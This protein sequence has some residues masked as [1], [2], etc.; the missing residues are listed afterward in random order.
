LRYAMKFK[1]YENWQHFIVFI[2]SPDTG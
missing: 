1:L 2:H